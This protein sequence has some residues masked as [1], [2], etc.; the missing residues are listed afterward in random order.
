MHGN[1]AVQWKAS[2]SALDIVRTA[3]AVA[4]KSNFAAGSARC[5]S[6]NSLALVLRMR[7]LGRVGTYLSDPRPS[8]P[9]HLAPHPPA[10][11][12]WI[13]PRLDLGLLVPTPFQPSKR[14]VTQALSADATSMR[15]LKTPLYNIAPIAHDPLQVGPWSG[16]SPSPEVLL[17][18][19]ELKFPLSFPHFPFMFSLF[20]L[21]SRPPFLLPVSSI[22]ALPSLSIGLVPAVSRPGPI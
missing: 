18:Y 2:P 4:S 19:I 21:D 5:P 15:S 3:R 11:R 17:L 22:P 8:P 13:K 7:M 20:V 10:P 12:A 14:R 9:H 1:G 6:V 16:L